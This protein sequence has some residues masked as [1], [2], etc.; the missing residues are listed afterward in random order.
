LILDPSYPDI[1]QDN[2]IQR[3]WKNAYGDIKEELPPDMPKPLGKEVDL[4]LHV[5]SS[6]ASDEINR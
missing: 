5:D 4:R 2:F 1:D 6:H 3:D